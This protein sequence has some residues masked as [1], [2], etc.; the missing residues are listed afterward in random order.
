MASHNRV[1]VLLFSASSGGLPTD[2]VTF[3]RLLRDQGYATGLVGEWARGGEGGQCT[4]DRKWM[5]DRT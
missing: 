2:E 4:S 1:G 5:A 3:A